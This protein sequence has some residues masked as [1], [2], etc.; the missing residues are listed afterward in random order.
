L[1]RHIDRA[2]GIRRRYRW[3]EQV[4]FGMFCRYVLP[5]NAHQ[6]IWE[7][8]YEYY[9]SKYAGLVD[10]MPDASMR[11]VGEIICDEIK[12]DFD[13][14]AKTWRPYPF[15]L[16]ANFR[17]I[18]LARIG[19]C[20]DINSASIAALRSMGIPAVLNQVPNWGN[21]NASH[22]W[23][24]IPDGNSGLKDKYDNTQRPF[25]SFADIVIDDM[26]WMVEPVD[27]ADLPP[28]ID[29]R[30]CRTVPKVFRAGYSLQKEALSLCSGEPMPSNIGNPCLED[31]TDR[32][33]VCRDVEIQLPKSKGH[34]I[35]Y[36]C[37]YDPDNISWIPVDKAEIK[38]G[39]A[40]FKKMGVNVLYLPACYAGDNIIPAGDPFILLEDGSRTMLKADN[41]QQIT[42]EFYIKTP[43]RSHVKFYAEILKGSTIGIADRKDL[44]DSLVLHRIEKTPFYEQQIVVNQPKR[45]RYAYFNFTDKRYGFLAELSFWERDENGNEVE[46]KGASFGNPGVTGGETDKAFDKN[47]VSYY[48][49]YLYGEYYMGIDFGKPVEINR[50]KFCPRSDDNGIVPG[51]NYEL[52]YWEN[53][54]QSLGRQTGR[55]DYKLV[56]NNVPEN[57]LLR[58][59]N[60]TRGKE[61][62]PFTYRNGKQIF[63]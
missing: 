9:E 18:V 19:E 8:V 42:A 5:Y 34:Q 32:Y 11:E 46:L 39:K 30:Y 52:F 26:Y 15:L 2:F 25:K 20:A 57:A 38:R 33:V 3:S 22:F 24:E 21:S 10:S 29:I 63:W 1:I 31:I 23:T 50:I 54:W 51:E 48:N 56:Y 59:H 49:R 43:Y 7:G 12:R 37:C 14:G 62:R 41:T 44:T 53:G 47:R 40:F 61:N 13:P 16:P 36:L 27:S 17:N 60:H 4:D 28:Y 6:S 55:D 45:A 58:I 35:A